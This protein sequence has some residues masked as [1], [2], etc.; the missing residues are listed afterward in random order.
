MTTELSNERI[1]LA[2]PT[3]I[4]EATHM[5]PS[6]LKQEIAVM[7]FQKRKLTLGQ[8]SKLADMSQYQFQHLLA[9]RQIPIHYG[10]DDFKA[11]LNTLKEIKDL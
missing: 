3:E 11:D 1:G 2:I 5:S 10:V 4:V 9:S 8:A 7:L 6:E